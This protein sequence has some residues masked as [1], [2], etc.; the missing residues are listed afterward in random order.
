MRVSFIVV[1][2][3]V[4]LA[5]NTGGQV[6]AQAALPE[7]ITLPISRSSYTTEYKL[8]CRRVETAPVFSNGTEGWLE[9]LRKNLH[10]DVPKLNGCPPG[11]Y[12]VRINYVIGRD[13]CISLTK[14][15]TNFGYGMEKEAIRVICQSPK[16][17]SATQNGR[18]VNSYRFQLVTFEVCA[19]AN[20]FLFSVNSSVH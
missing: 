5:F 20:E 8:T 9:Y 18:I 17:L 3:H 13:G 2:L 6:K 10:T 11:N 14:P 7:K 16:W 19:V 12:T 1:V 4:A 15:I